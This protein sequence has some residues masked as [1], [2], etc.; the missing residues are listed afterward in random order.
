FKDIDATKQT[1]SWYAGSTLGAFSANDLSSSLSSFS[2]QVSSAIASTPGGSGGSGFGGGS[3]G[4]GGG[5][6]GG[7]RGRGPGSR[8]S[9]VAAEA[10][11]A[12]SRLAALRRVR[13]DA[14]APAAHDLGAVGRC[15]R[16]AQERDRFLRIARKL[17]DTDAAVHRARVANDVEG[18][19]QHKEQPDRDHRRVVAG[20]E[21]RQ[22]DEERVVR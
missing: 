8:R 9:P 5:G 4:G 15:E 3:G 1:S 21:R 10:G 6:G 7:S 17:R 13:S 20:G 2:N 16:R 19:G 22:D 12:R 18:L 14:V 11:D